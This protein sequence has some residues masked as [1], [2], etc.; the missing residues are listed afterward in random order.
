M[1]DNIQ[2]CI[3]YALSLGN[4]AIWAHVASRVA[5]LLR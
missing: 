2:T 1:K 3:A 4:V 5:E